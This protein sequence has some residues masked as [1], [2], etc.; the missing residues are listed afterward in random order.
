MWG[1]FWGMEG[2]SPH[3]MIGPRPTGHI[4]LECRNEAAAMLNNSERD[5][6]QA[7]FQESVAACSAALDGQEVWIAR[8]EN[9]TRMRFAIGT[10]YVPDGEHVILDE[11]LEDARNAIIDSPNEDADFTDGEPFRAVLEDLQRAELIELEG[12]WILFDSGIND[13]VAFT[14]EIEAGRY[15]SLA[16]GHV[17]MR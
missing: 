5:E 8:P 10:R 1:G 6:N 17:L 3:R 16:G 9:C 4:A 14:R 13:F 15:D 12:N 11:L 7:Q 2:N